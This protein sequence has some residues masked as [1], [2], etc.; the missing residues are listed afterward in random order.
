MGGTKPG[1]PVLVPRRKSVID[2][3]GAG[4]R[5]RI[6]SLSYMSAPAEHP[7]GIH[8]KYNSGEVVVLMDVPFN[9]TIEEALLWTGMPQEIEVS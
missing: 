4:I 6:I 5:Y 7:F 2:A 3:T 9:G 1:I 8:E